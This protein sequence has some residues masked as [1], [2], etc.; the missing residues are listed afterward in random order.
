MELRRLIFK[1][2]QMGLANGN[3]QSW[4]TARNGVNQGEKW[5]PKLKD[6]NGVLNFVG[7][8]ILER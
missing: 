3:C 2:E 1:V 5:I 7:E 8:E 6:E 4:K